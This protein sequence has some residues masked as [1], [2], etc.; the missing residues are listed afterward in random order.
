MSCWTVFG[1][2]MRYGAIATVPERALTREKPRILFRG[3]PRT[4]TLGVQRMLGNS[5]PSLK[6]VQT[7]SGNGIV[8]YCEPM[9]CDRP[10]VSRGT[11]SWRSLMRLSHRVQRCQIRVLI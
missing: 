9:Y 7:R 3:R 11:Y 8:A 1:S 4:H 5:G 6:V 10:L 2:G